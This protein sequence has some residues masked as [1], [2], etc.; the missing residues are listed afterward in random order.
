MIKSTIRMEKENT[1]KNY[2]FTRT[3]KR[4]KFSARDNL[5][6]EKRFEAS[7]SVLFTKPVTPPLQ[8]ASRKL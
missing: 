6:E 2:Q 7:L 8:R 4:T 3:F 5:L 1:R